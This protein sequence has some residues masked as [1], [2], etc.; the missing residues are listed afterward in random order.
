MAVGVLTQNMV[1][2]GA[3]VACVPDGDPTKM[4]IGY[5][6]IHLVGL[7]LAQRNGDGPPITMEV[8]SMTAMDG[9]GRQG[10][11]T[12]IGHPQS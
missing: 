1:I 4:A 10:Q 3:R 7:G 5:G 12:S 11:D 9:V 2:F 6:S 8:G